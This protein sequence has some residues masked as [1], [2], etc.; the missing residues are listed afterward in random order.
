MKVVNFFFRMGYK[1]NGITSGYSSAN[2]PEKGSNSFD[3]SNY[4]AF[5]F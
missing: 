4:T 1:Y 3:N 5:Y 2:C